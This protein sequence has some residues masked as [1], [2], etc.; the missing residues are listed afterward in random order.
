MFGTIKMSL[1]SYASLRKVRTRYQMFT[2][3]GPL[4]SVMVT[5]TKSCALGTYG[6]MY[7][8]TKGVRHHPISNGNKLSWEDPKQRN[9]RIIDLVSDNNRRIDDRNGKVW[10]EKNRE[11]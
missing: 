11:S 2:K 10:G 3:T 5:T 7:A 4:I 8:Q 9:S 1:I 6:I